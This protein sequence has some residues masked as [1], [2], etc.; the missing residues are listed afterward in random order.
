MMKKWT[1]DHAPRLAIKEC[2]IGRQVCLHCI[3]VKDAWQINSGGKECD[4]DR[5]DGN[6]LE[7]LHYGSLSRYEID[8]VNALFPYKGGAEDR[9][10]ETK[11]A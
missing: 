4:E 6:S 2:P 9:A 3:S 11:L 1:G 8:V 10:A 7:V 5:N